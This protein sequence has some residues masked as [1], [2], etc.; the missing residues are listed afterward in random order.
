VESVPIEPQRHS[1]KEPPPKGGE[2][3]SS[4]AR[5]PRVGEWFW[6][7]RRMAELRQKARWEARNSEKFTGRARLAAELASHALDAE[8]HLSAPAEGLACELYRESIYW[9]LRSKGLQGAGSESSPDVPVPNGLELARLW[10]S[11]PRELADS[12]DPGLLERAERGFVHHSF[13]EFAEL[14]PDE[15]ARMAR[16]LGQVAAL[17]LRLSETARQEIDR[18]WTERA[19]RVGAVALVLVAVLVAISSAKA[20]REASA[21]LAPGKAWRTSSTHGKYGCRSPLQRCGESPH[22]FFHTKEESEPWVEIDLGSPERVSAVR[23]DNRE[24]CCSERAVPLLVEVSTDRKRYEQVARRDTAFKSWRAEFT[25][26]PVRFVRVR[27]PGR[28]SLHLAR[29]RVLGE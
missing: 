15:Q 18:V 21:D 23:I 9:A 20:W 2:A 26:V 4:A 16:E 10:Q 8:A 12:L 22:F 11:L 25:P 19:V 14:P 1:P 5:R 27:A 6:R 7:T 13:V 28:T 17:L 29:V 3:A 24:D